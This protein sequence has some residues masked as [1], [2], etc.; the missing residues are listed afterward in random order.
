MRKNIGGK[1]IASG[2]F[3]CV[4]NP[5]IKCK[6][7]KNKDAGITKLM[8]IKYAK[9]EYKEILEIKALLDDIPNYNDY[10]LL[11]GFSLCKPEELTKEDLEKFDKKCKSLR[12]IDITSTNVNQSLDKLL[13]L[14]MPFGGI[15]V[16]DYIEKEK[17]DYKKIHKMN[18]ALIELL[19]NG[20]VPMNQRDVFHCDIKDSN[21]LVKDDGNAGVKTRL[22][23]WGL[24][25]TYKNGGNIPKQLTNRPFQFNVPFSVVIFNDT[26]SKM[27]TEFLKKNKEPSFFNIRSF[28]INYVISWVNKRGPGHLKAINSIFKEFFER[29]LINIEEQFKEDLIEF[30]YTFYF[31]FEYISYVLFKFTR[32]G[33]FEKMEYFSE[34]FLKNLDIWGFTMTY[35]PILEY[36]SGYYNK[37]C[38]CELEI[39][40]KIKELILYV[41]GCSYVPVDVDKI[42]VKLEDLNALFLKADKKTTAHFQ[43]KRPTSSLTHSK[44]KTKTKTSKSSSKSKTKRTYQKSKSSSRNKTSKHSI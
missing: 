25:T 43:E 1:A 19:K 37:L 34:V 3:G 30:D 36:L 23:D 29:G 12:K 41:I 18:A 2:G 27:Y 20:I 8:K 33:R 7:R 40:E 4:F 22:I 6:T 31:I 38:D 15:D 24:S 17:M 42:V 39:I 35:L 9:A 11:D 16:G 26:F 44:T 5:A 10:F 21:I 32:D 28:V 13:S 14:N